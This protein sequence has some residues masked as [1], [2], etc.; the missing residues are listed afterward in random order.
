MLIKELTQKDCRTILAQA[1]IA[2]LG[3]SLNDQPY[4]VPVCIAHESDYVYILSTPG[5]KI[6]WMRANPKVCIQVDETTDP[7]HWAS[8]I[9]YG[10]FQ[11]LRQPQFADECAKARK[12]LS[13]RS[14]WW[15]TPL[16]ERQMKVD[17]DVIDAI[18]FRIRIESMTGLETQT[19]DTTWPK[20]LLYPLGN[21]Q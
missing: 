9:A 21:R 19:E 14:Q 13:K 1:S 11:E 20:K 7:F 3:C 17:H 6:E 15:L 12:L 18:F 2:R 10:E 5:Q 16:A 4:V 8:I